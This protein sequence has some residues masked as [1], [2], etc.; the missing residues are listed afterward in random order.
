[1]TANERLAL[2]RVKVERA[3]HHLRELEVALNDFINCN[4][5]RIERE[6]DLHAGYNIIA[7]L[8]QLKNS[9]P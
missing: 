5:H 2:I 9:T 3:K 7:A 6:T 4:A 1:M 8:L